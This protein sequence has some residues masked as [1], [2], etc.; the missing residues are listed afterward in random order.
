MRPDAN[1]SDAATV[2]AVATQ[3][4]LVVGTPAYMSPE[5]MRG[6]SVDKR[7]DIWAFGCVLY[8]LITGR[9][10][11][12]RKTI[13]DTIAAILDRDPD[14]ESVRAT[15]PAP[16]EP[17]QAVSGQR[18]QAASSRHRRCAD[19]DRRDPVRSGEDYRPS[20]STSAGRGNAFGCGQPPRSVS[21]R[22]PAQDWP[23]SSRRARPRWRLPHSSRCPLAGRRLTLR[24]GPCHRLLPM[25]VTSSSLAPTRRARRRCG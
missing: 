25:A 7:T 23:S 8:Q 24:S 6:Q 12:A 2:T 14:W 21:P 13:S 19:S 15:A 5:Q 10:A 22:S 11:F 4:G 17:G 20:S 3:E 16:V 18:F 9:A 1:E